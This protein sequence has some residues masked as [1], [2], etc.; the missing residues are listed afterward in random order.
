MHSLAMPTKTSS[1]IQPLV[2]SKSNNQVKHRVHGV[3]LTTIA[4]QTN[5]AVAPCNPN[6]IRQW[7][8]TSCS[9]MTVRNFVR[10]Q[11]KSGK[12]ILEWNSD[13][14]KM[15]QVASN[16]QCLDVYM[17]SNRYRLRAS[18]CSSSNGNLQWNAANGKIYH[19]TYSNIC[20]NDPTDPNCVAQ[21]WQRCANNDNQVTPQT[22]PLHSNGVTLRPTPLHKPSSTPYHTTTEPT[23]AHTPAPTP[24]PTLAPTPTPTPAST[25]AP[26]V[27]SKYLCTISSRVVS[28]YYQGLYNNG[29]VGNANENFAYNP[30]TG[31]VQVQSNKQ[32]LDSYWDGAQ[33][34]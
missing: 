1:T 33:F 7:I 11:T 3:C 16:G 5:I 20:L 13:E 14:G 19:A 2:L 27:A 26:A 6:D 24:A 10:I 18:A 29:L 15:F 17:E 28:E 30:T 32:C 31:A 12:Y 9:D 8:S 25:P 34:Q 21:V 22:T 4:G 23:P